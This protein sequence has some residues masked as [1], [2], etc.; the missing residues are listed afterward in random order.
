MGTLAVWLQGAPY[1]A[2]EPLNSTDEDT[3]I[4]RRELTYSGSV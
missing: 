3:E 4:Q 2:A 1:Q